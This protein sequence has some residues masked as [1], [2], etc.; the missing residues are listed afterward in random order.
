MFHT[1]ALYCAELRFR[2]FREIEIPWRTRAAA[3]FR[4]GITRP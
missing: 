4:C 3:P 1:C 2:R